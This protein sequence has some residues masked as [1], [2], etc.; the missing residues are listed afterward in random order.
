M[1]SLIK[2]ARDIMRRMVMVLVVMI[3][4]NYPV[5]SE[6]LIPSTNLIGVIKLSE[7]V[8]ANVN[9]SGSDDISISQSTLKDIIKKEIVKNKIKQGTGS[10]LP[11]LKVF[12][13]GKGTGGG[14]VK[15]NVE[16]YLVTTMDSP[17]KKNNS[18]DAII[19]TDSISEEHIMKYDPNVKKIVN[20]V[21][22]PEDKI[23]AG[24]KAII[25]KLSK[26]ISAV[27]K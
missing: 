3:A 22:K 4:W 24:V 1:D 16:A 17:F 19:W 11:I 26:D 23:I 25:G 5:F 12:L 8:Y 18:I 10:G 14:G 13:S 6:D 20:V 9:L 2:K 7:T 27:N 15:F 21:G